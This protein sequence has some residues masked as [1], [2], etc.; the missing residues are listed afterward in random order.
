[1]IDTRPETTRPARGTLSGPT[2][3][4][5]CLLVA[6]TVGGCSSSK[7]MPSRNSPGQIPVGT[8]VASGVSA[9]A[10]TEITTSYLRFFD[11][12][13]AEAERLQLIQDGTA[14]SEAISQQQKSEFAKAASVK[15]TKVTVGSAKKATVIFTLLLDGSPSLLNQTGYAVRENGKWKV[16]GATFCSLLSAQG[17]PPAVCATASATTL[18]G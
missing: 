16:A 10:A 7:G 15:V 6:G 17:A 3:A 5:A 13:V 4:V 18:P 1:M 14:F 9:A 8:D 11:P 2:L 12:T